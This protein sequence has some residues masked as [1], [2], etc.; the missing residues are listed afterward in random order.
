MQKALHRQYAARQAS[1]RRIAARSEVE[2]PVV[3]SFLHAF[4]SRAFDAV[5]R[6]CSDDGLC[7]ETFQKLAPG[8]YVCIRK[9]RTYR[10]AA[11]KNSPMVAPFKVAQVRWCKEK[12]GGLH[13]RFGVGLQYC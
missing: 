9:N 1:E 11:R 5:A 8:Q 4:S 3:Y 10:S 6:N 12:S 7:M 13:R 2:V